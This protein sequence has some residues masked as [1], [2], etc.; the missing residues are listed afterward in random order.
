M[1]A[2]RMVVT[3]FW[4]SPLGAFLI[5]GSLITHFLLALWSLFRRSTLRMPAWEISQIVLGLSVIPLAAGHIAGTWGS[6]NLLNIDIDYVYVIESIGSNNWWT[7]RQLLLVL[8]VWLHVCTGLHFWLRL[9]SWYRPTLPVTYI[10]AV[11]IPLL[12]LVGVI[13]VSTELEQTSNAGP[14]SSQVSADYSYGSSTGNR[15]GN[16]SVDRYGATDRNYGSD[17]SFDSESE[18]WSLDDLKHVILGL[19][20]GLLVLTLVGR[21]LRIRVLRSKGEVKIHHPGGEKIVARMGQ[22]LLEAIREHGIP[23]ASLCG[24]RAR[25]TTC[26]VRIGQGLENFAPPEEVEQQALLRIKADPNV[27]LACQA[28]PN[29]DVQITPLVEPDIGIGAAR[30][31]GAVQGSEQQVVTM[32]VDLRDSTGMGEKH[33]PYDVLFILNRFFSE[34]IEVLDETHGHY[35]QFAGDGLMALYGLTRGLEQGCRD[36]L[37]GAARMQARIEKMNDHFSRELDQPLRIGIGINCGDAIV[38]TMGPPTSP[39]YTAIGDSV[40]AAARLEALCKEYGC[41]L[42]VA[43]K[44]A[45]MA[46]ADTGAWEAHT[47]VVRGKTES[48]QVYAVTEP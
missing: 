27:R 6:R 9:K 22:T 40:N 32:F 1:E 45:E 15:Y 16:S 17:T 20:Y 39:N 42:V 37:D 21:W 26:R 12:A 24:G 7:T 36:A 10:F 13:R 46:K 25:C 48:L 5:Y 2:M 11:L 34:M 38:G 23:H 8:I 47:A 19:F 14:Y 4:H 44:V 30:K 3:P 41:V 43:A 33:L 18:P 29:S 31:P 28:R 35:A